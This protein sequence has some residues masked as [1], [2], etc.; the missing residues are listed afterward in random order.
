MKQKLITLT[1]SDLHNIVKESVGRILKESIDYENVE[2]FNVLNDNFDG[3]WKS[4]LTANLYNKEGKC[5]G[6]LRD[7]HFVYDVENDKLMG[8]W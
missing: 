3:D 8:S 7:M 1:E 5:V 6:T 4:V 2:V